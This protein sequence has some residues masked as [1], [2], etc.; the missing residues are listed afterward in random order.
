VVLEIKQALGGGEFEAARTRISAELRGKPSKRLKEELSELRVRVEELAGDLQA[1]LAAVE[2]LILEDPQEAE[3]YIRKTYLTVDHD[4]RL[5]ILEAAQAVDDENYRIYGRRVDCCIDAYEA[6]TVGARPDLFRMIEQNIERCLA[7]EPS[8]GNPVWRSATNFFGE[9]IMAKGEVK[10][11]LDSIISQCTALS[12]RA[13]VTLR[14]RL[15]R[16]SRYKEDRNSADA[17][18]LLKDISSAR[19]ASSKSMQPYYEWLELDAYKSLER[20]EELSRRLSE[21][22]LNSELAGSREYLRRKSDFLLKFNGDLHGAIGALKQAVNAEIT[23]S[24]IARLAFLME[25]SEDAAGIAELSARHSSRLPSV[26]R[27]ALR[28]SELVAQGDHEG[29]LAQLRSAFSKQLVGAGQR[30]IEIHDLLLLTRFS[31]ASTI[32]KN[33]LDELGWNKLEFGEHIINYELAQLRQG[34]PVNK[35]RLGEL[36]ESSPSEQVKACA[37]VLVGDHAKAK[38]GFVSLMREDRENQFEIPRWAIFQDDKGRAFIR[39]VL[40]A[41]G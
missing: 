4:E 12:S 16:W 1:A 39:G 23:R 9:C 8:I 40:D 11:K 34:Q 24:D 3:N 2:S 29:A 35:R 41:A 25:L 6:G 27:I 36:I 13:T 30:M 33:L 26:D 15:K 28:R 7:L 32:A 18:A 20:R 17:D 22:A 37:S 5:K 14:A 38:E 19:L 31:E 10:A 21:L